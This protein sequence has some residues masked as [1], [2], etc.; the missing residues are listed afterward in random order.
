M[1]PSSRPISSFD[2]LAVR[3]AEKTDA[4]ADKLQDT[5]DETERRF[6]DQHKGFKT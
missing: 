1:P 5:R 3:L 2:E 4:I 6:E